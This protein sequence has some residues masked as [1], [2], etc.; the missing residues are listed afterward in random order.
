M[1]ISPSR[2]GLAAAVAIVEVELTGVGWVGL[3]PKPE[4]AR[5]Q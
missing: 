5:C 2:S 4:K 1:R 3:R